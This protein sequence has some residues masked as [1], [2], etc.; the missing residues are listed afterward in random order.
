M[1]KLTHTLLISTALMS[2]HAMSS[3]F[4]YNYIDLKVGEIEIDGSDTEGDYTSISG[5]Y[6][7]EG[8]VYA[9]MEISSKEYDSSDAE[10]DYLKYGVGMHTAMGSGA[11]LYGTFQVVEQDV[12]GSEDIGNQI[13]LGIRI[14]VSKSLELHGKLMRLKFDEDPYTGYT[15]AA[16]FYL[17]PNMAIGGGIEFWERDGASDTEIMY[18]NAR[19]NF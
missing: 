12:D 18:V 1:K 8:K 6:E 13:D 11:D 5:G 7:I 2:T 15:T 14:A 16:R 4:S 3:G 17:N 9:T 10:Y 19:F